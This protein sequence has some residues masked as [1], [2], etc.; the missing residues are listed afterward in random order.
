M[1]KWLL[2]GIVAATV[3]LF[4]VM[5]A[6]AHSWY[7]PDCCS[8]DDCAPVH[9]SDVRITNEGYELPDGFVFKYGNRRI[10]PS[11]DGDFHVCTNKK[12]PS[13]H[14]CIYVPLSG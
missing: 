3:I 7:E 1:C 6:M 5:H 14:Y 2:V 11:R 4:A 9:V 10:R 13:I 12:D 8:G